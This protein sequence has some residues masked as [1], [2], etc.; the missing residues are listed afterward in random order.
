MPAPTAAADWPLVRVLALIVFREM[1]EA[2]TFTLEAYSPPTVAAFPPVASAANELP[3]T[4][5][6]ESVTTF[7]YTCPTAAAFPP[8]DVADPTLPD[9]E[10]C[11]R[12]ISGEYS[13]VAVTFAESP[14]ESTALPLT[15]EPLSVIFVSLKAPA[16][17]VCPVAP[18]VFVPPVFPVTLELVSASGAPVTYSV[19]TVVAGLAV[20]ELAP[21]L[22]PLT[23]V[24][25]SETSAP[26]PEST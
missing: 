22:F 6:F 3:F 23:V 20:V 24:F 9:T 10:L 7:P 1:V 18:G 8:L 17:T 19:P 13:A 2:L 5:D 12:W 14:I 11:V 21:A 25:V 15:E 4:V 26:D 16:A